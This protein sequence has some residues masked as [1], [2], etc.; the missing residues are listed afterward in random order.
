VCVCVCVRACVCV[1]MYVYVY[2]C[3]Y[4]SSQSLQILEGSIQSTFSFDSNKY[5]IWVCGIKSHLNARI[6]Q[7]LR[8]NNRPIE[9]GYVGHT[10]G[11]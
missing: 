9:I 6:Q 3:M 2:V 11:L 8:S 5:N 1:C 7:N 4:D 10:E